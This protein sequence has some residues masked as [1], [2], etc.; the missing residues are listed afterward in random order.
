M[1][2]YIPQLGIDP[3]GKVNWVAYPG[4]L[5]LYK[6][7]SIYSSPRGDGSGKKVTHVALFQGGLELYKKQHI[8]HVAQRGIESGEKGDSI[9]N[10]PGGL[11]PA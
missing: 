7:L 1:N 2:M 9:D 8:I 10:L 11:R 3:G 6:D 4:G 5:E